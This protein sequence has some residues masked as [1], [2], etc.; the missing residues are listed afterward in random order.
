MQFMISMEFTD[1]G[2]R[3]IKDELEAHESRPC[4]R[5]EVRY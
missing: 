2:I 3:T 1:Q 4:T 5:Q